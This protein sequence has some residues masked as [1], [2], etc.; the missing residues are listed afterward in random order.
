ML[1]GDFGFEECY[2]I[3]I[4]ALPTKFANKNSETLV[5]DSLKRYDTCIPRIGKLG[6]SVQMDFFNDLGFACTR[7]FLAWKLRDE[8]KLGNF[9]FTDLK[10]ADEID[11][12]SKLFVNFFDD[13][14]DYNFHKIEKGD[15]D[16]DNVEKAKEMFPGIFLPWFKKKTGKDFQNMDLFIRSQV[17]FGFTYTI[18]PLYGL[19]SVNGTR[20]YL[21]TDRLN[22]PSRVLRT[23][24]H[25]L[26][27]NAIRFYEIHQLRTDLFEAAMMISPTKYPKMEIRGILSEI[28]DC[29]ESD[30][31]Q[32]YIAKP[33]PFCDLG[34]NQHGFF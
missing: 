22:I 32:E 29:F 10:I 5:I 26:C 4:K 24:L 6:L 13:F 1:K 28:G 9:T 23:I 16:F 8:G 2:N 31:L 12:K 17:F 3:R 20:I 14:A 27:H 25:E 11:T 7:P 34:E 15:L 30:E 19:S 21:N 33:G 18:H